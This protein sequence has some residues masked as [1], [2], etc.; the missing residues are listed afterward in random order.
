MVVPSPRAPTAAT[1]RNSR[2]RVYLKLP[3][4][5]VNP[6]YV[7]EI[8]LPPPPRLPTL[9]CGAIA[10][11]GRSPAGLHGHEPRISDMSPRP[12][13]IPRTTHPVRIT[14]PL[15]RRASGTEEPR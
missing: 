5:I 12:W 4:G 13:T 10:T 7:A 6:V 8:G 2:R 9:S 3:R 14:I 11:L 15:Q 1:E